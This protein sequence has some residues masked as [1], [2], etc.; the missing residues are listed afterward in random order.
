MTSGSTSKRID[1]IRA[2]DFVLS[3]SETDPNGPLELKR[4]QEVYNR[5]ARLLRLRVNG[6]DVTTT[7]EHPFVVAGRGWVNADQ[8][9]PGDALLTH[10]GAT[11]TIEEVEKLGAVAPVYNF[12]VSDFHMYYVGSPAWGFDVWVHNNNRSCP[13]GVDGLPVQQAVAP[14]SGKPPIQGP[15]RPYNE[16]KKSPTP[17]YDDHH[18]DPPLGRTNP[19]YPTGPTIRVRNDNSGGKVPGGVNMHTA[20]GGFQTSLREHITKD[21]RMTIKE[22]NA[23]SDS[24]RHM[25]LRRYYASL[26]IPFPLE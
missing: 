22:W 2:G 10:E 11:V 8:L 18:L 14:I 15:V 12:Q 21:L 25:H 3:R 17:G 6:K 19:N 4:V 26:G 5:V 16:A 1:E 9:A 13:D 20:K 24:V 7:D 23:L